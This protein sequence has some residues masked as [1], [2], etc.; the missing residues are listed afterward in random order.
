MTPKNE[1][2]RH[3]R[4][5]APVWCPPRNRAGDPILTID[6]P[7]VRSA[8][9]GLMSPHNRAGER[10]CR[11]SDREAA[12]GCAWRSF[13]QISGTSGRCRQRLAMASG[14]VAS[15]IGTPPARRQAAAHTAGSSPRSRFGSRCAHATQAP[16]AWTS[17]LRS[18]LSG[19]GI[20]AW[21]MPRA[22]A[23]TIAGA[24]CWRKR[25]AE[26]AELGAALVNRT[27]QAAAYGTWAR[28]ERLASSRAPTGRPSSSASTRSQ[29]S[30]PTASSCW[31][32]AAA[33]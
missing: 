16:I 10:R 4:W 20:Q 3:S 22:A 12:R 18:I 21:A 6:A 29:D 5:S 26:S 32:S 30:T 7:V 31:R 9:T 27:A 14:L 19:S 25:L 15:A 24:A 28:A 23:R 13:W 11:G 1:P 8:V 2:D 17:R 33:R